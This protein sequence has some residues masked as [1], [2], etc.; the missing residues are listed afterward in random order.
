MTCFRV[1]LPVT[2]KSRIDAD[3][4]EEQ[5]RIEHE[6]DPSEQ[7]S[8]VQRAEAPAVSSPLSFSFILGVY[9]ISVSLMGI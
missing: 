8:G 9:L 6:I 2:G 5:G 7:S 4:T 1:F 3:V